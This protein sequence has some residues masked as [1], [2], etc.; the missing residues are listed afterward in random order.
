MQNKL[1]LSVVCL[2]AFK[3]RLTH[4]GRWYSR[5]FSQGNLS[6]VERL[7]PLHE[8]CCIATGAASR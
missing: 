6:G 5:F 1:E 7:S 8:L 2:S 3:D 4:G